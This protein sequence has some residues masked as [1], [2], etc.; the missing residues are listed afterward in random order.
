MADENKKAVTKE[1]F[2]SLLRYYGV[3]R[4]NVIILNN[5]NTCSRNGSLTLSIM[6]NKLYVDLIL[7]S[8]VFIEDATIPTLLMLGF[9]INLT[10]EEI[11]YIEN[12]AETTVEGEGEFSYSL[13]TG[14]TLETVTLSST[15]SGTDTQNLI[16]SVTNNILKLTFSHSE[17]KAALTELGATR[18][19]FKGSTASY[20]YTWEILLT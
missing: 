16:I 11:G 2:D 17:I 6:G 15:N 4:G 18:R 1:E 10:N 19:Y 8:T 20:K 5:T 9:G 13:Y 14:S 7:T 3:L 12:L